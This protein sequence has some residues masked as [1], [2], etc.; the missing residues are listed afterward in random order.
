[1]ATGNHFQF[2]RDNVN[3][4]GF[5]DDYLGRL[6]ALS[7]DIEALTGEPLKV[8]S[9]FRSNEEQAALYAARQ[10]GRARYSNIDLMKQYDYVGLKTFIKQRN[11][12]DF[13]LLFNVFP[14]KIYPFDYQ[15]Y[16]NSPE[17]FIMV[18]SNCLTGEAVYLE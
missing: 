12:M 1:M 2:A 9:G 17:R 15:T 10:R 11:I 4:E 18:T 16:F 5:D 14:K 13:N 6:N 8:T 7:K 3:L